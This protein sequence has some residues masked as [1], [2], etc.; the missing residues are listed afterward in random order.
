MDDISESDITNSTLYKV[1]VQ[2]NIAG[3]MSNYVISK[4]PVEDIVMF[5]VFCE[6]DK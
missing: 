2:T 1:H 3:V 6:I 5:P 4:Q